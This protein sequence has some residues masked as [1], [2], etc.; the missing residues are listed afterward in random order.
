M[1]FVGNFRHSPNAEGLLWFMTEVLPHITIANPEAVLVV[2]GTD[3]P[4]S[5]LTVVER[6]ANVRFTRYVEDIREPLRRYSTFVCPI[7]SGSGIRVKL[8]QA[9]ATGIPVVSTSLGAEGLAGGN[10]SLCEIADAP[11]D[12]AA[13][14]LRVLAS[15][16]YAGQLANRAR[17]FVESHMDGTVVTGRLLEVYRRELTQAR[18]ASY[19]L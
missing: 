8:L 13:A 5:M 1:L 15:R 12:F 19:Y 2:A 11:D 18:R 9:F 16:E 6:H 14:V 10:G 7:L 4:P 3:A 17:R